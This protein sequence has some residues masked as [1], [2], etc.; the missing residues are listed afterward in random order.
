MQ[1][2][3]LRQIPLRT[4]QKGKGKPQEPEGHRAEGDSPFGDDRSARYGSEGEG[5]PEV[6]RQRRQ[7]KGHHSLQGPPDKAWRH[8]NGR[9]GRFL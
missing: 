9:D 6:P 2:Y 7:G 8:W 4:D 3:G 1:N 5:L